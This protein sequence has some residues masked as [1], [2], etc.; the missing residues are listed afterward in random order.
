MKKHFSTFFNRLVAKHMNDPYN[1]TSISNG[2]SLRKEGE[3]NSKLLE[4]VLNYKQENLTHSE[5]KRDI[6]DKVAAQ[7]EY[8]EST[9]SQSN[10]ELLETPE[11][12]KYVQEEADILGKKQEP[13]PT[14]NSVELTN[15]L[16]N[17]DREQTAPQTFPDKDFNSFQPTVSPPTTTKSELGQLTSQSPKTL[18]SAAQTQ[19][20]MPGSFLSS[21]VGTIAAVLLLGLIGLLIYLVYK[22]C[23]N[24]MRK[25]YK[26]LSST[27]K[28]EEDDSC[29]ELLDKEGRNELSQDETAAATV[30]EDLNLSQIPPDLEDILVM[31]LDVPHGAES[32]QFGWQKV[33]NAAGISRCE[34][35]YYEHL[36]GKN[37][38]PTKLLLEKLGS[39]GRTISYLID[40]LQKPRVE[41]GN[42]AKTIR[43]RV[44]RI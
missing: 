5:T 12:N 43:H 24:K 8:K 11:I 7:E 20:I 10:F 6:S 21:F 38:S 14:K 39:Q 9:N 13:S 27:S 17:E 22:K 26:K 3:E 30:L 29:D 42:V 44:T 34:L 18:T 36:G 41:L 23:F 15:I 31:K 2:S 35:K 37:R 19:L 4:S 25:G 28:L 16:A 1:T 32:Q 40:V 33:G